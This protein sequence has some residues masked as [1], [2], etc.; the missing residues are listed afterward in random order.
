[1]R[2]LSSNEARFLSFGRVPQTRKLLG[3]FSISAELPSHSI[4]K[5]TGCQIAGHK[6]GAAHQE[7]LLVVDELED[8]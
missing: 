8:H 2:S 3:S 7:P 1:M 6:K 5:S 4:Q